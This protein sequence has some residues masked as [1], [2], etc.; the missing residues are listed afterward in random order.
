MDFFDIDFKASDA[1]SLVRENRSS[2]ERV[3][4][5]LHGQIILKVKAAA[6]RN[7]LYTTFKMPLIMLG[8]SN[9]N[10]ERALHWII[11]RLESDGFYIQAD[12][13]SRYLIIRWADPKADDGVGKSKS[14][15]KSA[16]KKVRFN[17]P[18]PSLFNL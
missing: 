6:E 9:Y 15:S 7:R 11:K 14:T 2:R 16:S 13:R 12:L 4:Q 18:Q 17:V 8:F 1:R 3:F 10:P 5:K